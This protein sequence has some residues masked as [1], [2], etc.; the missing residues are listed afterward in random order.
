MM[1]Q[2]HFTNCSPESQTEYHCPICKFPTD[3]PGPCEFC[4]YDPDQPLPIELTLKGEA[5]C[6]HESDAD[7]FMAMARV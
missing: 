3:Q 7:Y 2:E 5:A 4:Q 1:H 6:W